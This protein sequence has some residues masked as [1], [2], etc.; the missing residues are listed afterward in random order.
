[1]LCKSEINIEE[2]NDTY[3]RIVELIGIDDAIKLSESFAGQS[4]TF[5]KDGN[6]DY[7]LSEIADCI[8]DAKAKVLSKGFYGERVYFG[9][10]KRALKAQLHGKIRKE[11]NGYNYRELSK[12]YGY[13]ERTIRHIYSEV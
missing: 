2:L 9:S 4:L 5:R 12:K 11:C 8:G 10:L 1:M 6:L 13:T 7:G 3:Y